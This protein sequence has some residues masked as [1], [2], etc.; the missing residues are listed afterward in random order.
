MKFDF[1]PRAYEGEGLNGGTPP[2]AAGAP[3]PPMNGG[4]PPPAPWYTG[5][6]DDATVGYLQTR[7]PSDLNDPVKVA[8]GAIKSHR[9]AERHLG[10]DPAQLLRIPV[11]ADDADGWNNVH[12]RLGRPDN[13]TDYELKDHKGADLDEGTAAAFRAAAHKANLSK[14]AAKVLAS[15]MAKFGEAQAENARLEHENRLVGAKAELTKNWG[16]NFAVNK[17][18]AKAGASAVGFDRDIV[19]ALEKTAGYAK[20]MEAL[21]KIGASTQEGKFVQGGQNGGASGQPMTLQQAME[22]KNDL[23][24]DAV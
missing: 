16:A 18:M 20:T 23:F 5:K 19:E 1:F 21:R 4:T 11:K 14:D 8:L 17:E 10:V 3:P 7:Y 15:E 24:N 22:K 12:K 6:I 2:P 9:E 13:A